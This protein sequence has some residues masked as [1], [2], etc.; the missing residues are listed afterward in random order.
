MKLAA[1]LTEAGITA[2]DF[3]KRVEVAAPTV[4]RLRNGTRLPS[5]ALAQRIARET[6]GKVMPDDFFQ[7]IERV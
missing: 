5:L 4:T 3:A 1:Y 6:G 2:S 7:E